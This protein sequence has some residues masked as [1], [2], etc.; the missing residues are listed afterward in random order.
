MLALKI[1]SN[2]DKLLRC[3]AGALVVL[4]CAVLLGLYFHSKEMPENVSLSPTRPQ[5]SPN[6]GDY[7]VQA[8]KLLTPDIDSIPP[9]SETIAQAA[10]SYGAYR[11][12]T[13]AQKVAI[14]QENQPAFAKLQEG[15]T[16]V[17]RWVQ[18][19]LIFGAP[20]D[21]L[22]SFYFRK[23]A[24]ALR[25]ASETCEEQGDWV[26]AMNYRI[27]GINLG[28]DVQRDAGI[29]GRLVSVAC[30][31]ISLHD[32]EKIVNNLDS[33]FAKTD[34]LRICKIDSESTPLYSTLVEEKWSTQNF[35]LSSFKSRNWRNA[36]FA[37]NINPTVPI[38]YDLLSPREA[39]DGFTEYMS[40]EFDYARLSWPEQISH[41]QP[42]PANPLLA[43][44]FFTNYRHVFFYV[45]LTQTSDRFLELELALHAYR[46]DHGVYP[47]TL[48]Q[49]TPGYLPTLPIDPFSNNQPFK[50]RPNGKAGYL[51]YSVG[52]DAVD[53]GGIPIQDPYHK[54]NPYFPRS[55]NVKGDIV[56]GVNVF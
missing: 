48:T 41:N 55:D 9:D 7:F 39:Y 35:F 4:G 23:M 53:N 26:D 15:L 54:E 19:P 32:A 46:L 10:A 34:A 12:Y 25:A 29:N 22:S 45:N 1:P 42:S 49:L 13:L 44:L 16:S 28:V 17:H 51:L 52:P 18:E 14:I 21:G 20:V 6:A 8:A 11:Q 33:R 50:Y 24:R 37:G 56:A 5:P 36:F 47:T 31:V 3:S 38:Q 43:N 27:D 2:V 40:R 30:N